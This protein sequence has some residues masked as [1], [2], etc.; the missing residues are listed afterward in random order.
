MKTITLGIVGAGPNALYALDFILR[1]SHE[2]PLQKL[3]LNI[4]VFEKNSEYG[5]GLH[6]TSTLPEALL[7]RIAGQIS[8]C[9][10][11][12]ISLNLKDHNNYFET[13][14]EWS[15][16]Q[17]IKTN[18]SKYNFKSEDW[19]PRYIL[20]E[21]LTSQFQ[22]IIKLLEKNKNI[23]IR[24]L[25][26]CV[27]DIQLENGE[28]LLKTKKNNYFYNEILIV[29]G[30][31]KNHGNK[32]FYNFFK[33]NYLNYINYFPNPFPLSKMINKIKKLNKNKILV[34]GG[35]A[36]GIDVI[37]SLLVNIPGLK[38]YP[39]TRSGLIAYA[40]PINQKFR[41]QHFYKGKLLKSDFITDFLNFNNNISY[42]EVEEFMMNLLEFET[43][44]AYFNVIS[45]INFYS[46]NNTN[47]FCPKSN[48][49]EFKKFVKKAKNKYKREIFKLAE[50]F[51]SKLEDKDINK[52]FSNSLIFLFKLFNK[53]KSIKNYNLHGESKKA[54]ISSFSEFIYFDWNKLIT[55]L[56][57]MFKNETNNHESVL[58]WMWHDLEHAMAGNL[59]SPLKF[60][61]D[62]VFRDCRQ[63]IMTPLRKDAAWSS[64]Y[65]E[66]I[67]K[68]FLPIH[69]RLAD[70]SS[71]EIYKFIYNNAKKGKV[72]FIFSN[73]L[74]TEVAKNKYFLKNNDHKCPIDIVIEAITSTNHLVNISDELIN[75]LLKSKILD[76]TVSNSG[77][78]IGLNL[79]INFN[80][81]TIDNKTLRNFTILGA[82]SEGRQVFNHT[83][84]RSD[85]MYPVLNNIN[86]WGKS[87][88]KKI[89]N[90]ELKN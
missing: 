34:I 54:L 8:L 59:T 57:H 23:H 52:N 53:S 1:A 26:E 30:T 36:T 89:K 4:D 38:I 88:Y 51:I 80:P 83:L 48:L 84:G 69:N 15:N 68:T 81:I 56:D 55:P 72:N 40:R 58:K 75:N 74:E 16:Y 12:K 20:G 87:F 31:P 45:N 33:K 62:G 18:D 47:E 37:N 50:M 21:A 61:T 73:K 43:N 44:H 6:S 9:S 19:P 13:F 82:A 70:G 29:K 60:V 10:K 49:G 63:Q 90:Y 17:Y 86:N 64:K 76:M 5:S 22:V 25:N 78:K 27:K 39:H 77:Y 46:D 65:H 66:V 28:Y 24:L 32:I 42:S 79:D 35:G 67:I 11:K 41:Q 85:D 2:S 7:N 3:M 71:I 14:L